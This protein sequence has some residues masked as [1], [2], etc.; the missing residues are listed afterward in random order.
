MKSTLL[1]AVLFLV[2]L[3]AS[4]WLLGVFERSPVEEPADKPVTAAGGGATAPDLATAEPKE[5]PRPAVPEV[6][7]PV[8]VLVLGESPRSFTMWLPILLRLDPK[9][10]WRMWLAEA[11]APGVATHAEDVPPLEAKPDAAVLDGL[12][13]LVLAGVDPSRFGDDF[14]RRVTERVRAKSMGLLVLGEHRFGKAYA[15]HPVLKEV[16]PIRGVKAVA[17]ASPGSSILAGVFEKPRPFVVTSEGRRH[18]ASR[19]VPYPGWSEKHW[20]AQETGSQAWVTKFCSPAEGPTTDGVVL[21]EVDTGDGRMP[22]F[23]A[24]SGANGRVLWIGGFFDL[25]RSAYAGSASYDRARAL[26]V[27][28][29]AWLAGLLN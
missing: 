15:D 17:P 29:V 2:T 16:L 18:P 24:S 20:K 8:S 21:V 1:V 13:V 7:E 9:I 6:A 10:Q 12:R 19:I 26:G 3:A 22:A 27:S 4:L 25:E 11:P 5:E 23:L 28:W 14:W